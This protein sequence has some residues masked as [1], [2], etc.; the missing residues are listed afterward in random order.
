MNN[1]DKYR[2]ALIKAF[3]MLN[4]L[5]K[6]R[7]GDVLYMNTNAVQIIAEAFDLDYPLPDSLS[8][9][10]SKKAQPNEP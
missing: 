1:E 9:D 8:E 4:S 3:N 6:D 10:E 5:R 7:F 2:Q